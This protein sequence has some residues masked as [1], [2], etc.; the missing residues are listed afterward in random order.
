MPVVSPTPRAME[1]VGPD[2][3]LGDGVELVVGEGTDPA[4][5]KLL[6][7]VL[8][9]HGVRQP[10]VRERASGA[11]DV[12]VLLGEATRAD[13]ARALDGT[14][15]PDH[16]EAYGL[17]VTAGRAASGGTVALGGKDAAGQYYAVQ[18]FRQLLSGGTNTGAEKGSSARIAGVSV[19]D[20]PAMPLR[21]TIEGFYGPQWSPEERL[22]HM[23]F[24]GDT[25]SNTYVYAPKDDPYHREKWREPYPD[26]QL[27][28]LG[29][30]VERARERHVRFT[31]AVSPGNSICYSDPADVAALRAKLQALYDLG[32]RSF[33]V[34]LDDISYTKWNCPGDEKEF[35]APGRA[36]AARAQLGLLNAVQ[37][38]FVATHEGVEPL[39]TVPTE[40]GD[41]EE[42]AYKK[43]L[44]EG[45]D[46]DV[47][48]M[49]TGTAVVP[50]RIT[51]EEAARASELFGRKVFVWDN[52]P[53]NDFAR[54][55][56]R[57]LLAPY[58]KRDPGLSEHVTGLVSN[59][60]SQAGASK[61][62]VFTMA[63][64]AWNDRGYDRRRSGEQAARYLAG[65]DPRTTRALLTFVDLNHL[66]PTFGE[67]P[68]Q[69]QS[70]VL[71]SRLDAFQDR[72][73]SD[74]EG[75]VRELRPVADGIAEAPGILREGVSDRWF[76]ADAAKW[77]DAT[78]LWGAAL[79]HGL[80]AL[81]AVQ[82][83]DASRAERERAAMDEA[84]SA[85]SA[86]TVDPEE[87]S[88]VGPVKLGDPFLS[89][90]VDRVRSEQGG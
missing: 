24:L 37:R 52:Y 32:V 31:F 18:T 17:R 74:P 38:D 41:L 53:V 9:G 72:Y 13:I 22:D 76:L 70:P 21:G 15:V 88:Q 4:A 68:W 56:G 60:M 62:A 20:R 81:T 65:G 10:D 2:V 7:E 35:G 55:K 78:E 1:R 51:A 84:V 14:R 23:D 90:F 46:R 27:A 40:Y 75:A 30:L 86:I 47:E 49:W 48:V 12:T 33:S 89:R 43:T 82:D 26:E 63:D 45:L 8:R 58:D 57:L 80:R 66:A 73:G 50:P 19:S 39:Q 5:R 34:P 79:R 64:F 3:R 54:T 71:G 67:T 16:A 25:K 6:T 29:K 44:R 85:A 42:T 69:P 36:P 28:E 83:G 77:L 11:A 87:N 59:P 61:A